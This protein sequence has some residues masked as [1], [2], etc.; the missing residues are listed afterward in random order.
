MA[1][2][3]ANW[4]QLKGFPLSLA[5]KECLESTVP[6]LI[7]QLMPVICIDTTGLAGNSVI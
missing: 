3:R 6:E 5:N 7:F 1:R 2:R 4:V